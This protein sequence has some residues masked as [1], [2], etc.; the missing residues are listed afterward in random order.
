M[1]NFRQHPITSKQMLK[2]IILEEWRNIDNE[3]SSKLVL[4]MKN[5][6]TDV[7]KAKGYHTRY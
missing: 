3:T 1:G 2:N 4:S 6:L 5:R 7:I